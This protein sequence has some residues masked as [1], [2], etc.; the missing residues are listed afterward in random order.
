[1]EAKKIDFS[2]PFKANGK[3]YVKSTS[4]TVDEWK[5]FELLQAHVGFGMD[6]GSMLNRLNDVYSLWNKSQFADAAVKLHN[7]ISGV[8]DK[9]EKREHPTL[10][11][12]TLFLHE[13]GKRERWSEDL[14]E[15][16]INDWKQENI[17]V[18]C[19]FQLAAALVPNFLENLEMILGDTLTEREK[20]MKDQSITDKQG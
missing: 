16:K 1:M 17:D 15:N 9:L 7:L 14:A 13:E 10:M 2:K 6:F 8:A 18:S 11:I 19:F 20:E 4:L 5:E 3:K 12:C